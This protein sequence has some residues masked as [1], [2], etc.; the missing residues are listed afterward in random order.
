MRSFEVYSFLSSTC[1]N[2]PFTMRKRALC[3]LFIDAVGTEGSPFSLE[4]ACYFN[5]CFIVTLFCVNV[6][7]SLLFVNVYLEATL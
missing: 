6:L 2:W 4:R 7:T 3:F 1:L 5:V